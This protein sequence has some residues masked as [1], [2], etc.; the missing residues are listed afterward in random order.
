MLTCSLLRLARGLEIESARLK[1]D[2]RVKGGLGLGMYS[3]E[4]LFPLSSLNVR[5]S[6]PDIEF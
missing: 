4:L 2:G 5:E 3:L 1:T 6:A